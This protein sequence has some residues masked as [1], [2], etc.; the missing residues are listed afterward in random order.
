MVPDLIWAPD[1]F[2]LQKIWALGN[3]VPKKFGPLV[4]MPC[5]NFCAGPKQV[6]G[7]NQL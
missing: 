6:R 2:G 3:L 7:P 4:K 5:N 1:L